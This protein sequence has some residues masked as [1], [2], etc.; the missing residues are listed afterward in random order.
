MTQDE[1]ENLINSKISVAD[2]RIVEIVYANHPSI[3]EDNGKKEIAAIYNLPGGMRIIR[4][5]LPTSSAYGNAWREFIS[6]QQKLELV[7]NRMEAIKR[8]EIFE[9]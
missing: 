3:S 6:L 1:F 8:G 5:M 7:K 9:D 2:Y 4:D